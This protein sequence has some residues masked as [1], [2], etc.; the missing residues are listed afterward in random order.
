MGTSKGIWVCALLLINV[1]I[2]AQGAD[3]SYRSN[4]QGQSNSDERF[5][6]Y[7]RDYAGLDLDQ[8]SSDEGHSGEPSPAN[9]DQPSKEQS[10]SKADKTWY[11]HQRNSY[12]QSKLPAH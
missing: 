11:Y 5:N 12:D 4:G 3:S 2:Q 10:S 1:F 8:H 9:V 6:Q 7:N